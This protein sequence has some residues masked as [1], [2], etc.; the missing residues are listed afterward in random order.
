MLPLVIAKGC[1]LCKRASLRIKDQGSSIIRRNKTEISLA[2]AFGL[3]PIPLHETI[4]SNSPSAQRFLLLGK[5][6]GNSPR[7][8]FRRLDRVDPGTVKQSNQMMAR[9]NLSEAFQCM[10]KRSRSENVQTCSTSWA[11]L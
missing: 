2:T 9:R 6:P 10:E 5:K 1:V 11:K 4:T 8:E 7:G 3:C